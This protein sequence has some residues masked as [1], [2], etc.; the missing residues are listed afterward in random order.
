MLVGVWYL[1]VANVC[2][3]L[4]DRGAPEWLHLVVLWGVWSAFTLVLNGP[5]SLF[6]IVRAV[7]REQ[8]LAQAV[9]P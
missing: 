4:I 8:M 3:I 5:V 6:R 1:A 7:M 9:C 2:T